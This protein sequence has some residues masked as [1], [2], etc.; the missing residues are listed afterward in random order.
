[1]RPPNITFLIIKASWTEY[2][3]D[4]QSA[5]I[6]IKY[7]TSVTYSFVARCQFG[8]CEELLP[9]TDR[10]RFSPR[11]DA[12]KRIQNDSGM[13]A[14][15]IDRNDSQVRGSPHM[16]DNAV[17]LWDLVRSIWKLWLYVTREKASCSSR[18]SD[19]RIFECLILVYWPMTN[20]IFVLFQIWNE[21]PSNFTMC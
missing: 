3:A 16:Y 4:D 19:P 14:I 10:E 2:A 9:Q 20:F 18:L 5:N 17:W 8:E 21:H 11:W 6:S 7:C 13:L 12:I 1:M 15:P